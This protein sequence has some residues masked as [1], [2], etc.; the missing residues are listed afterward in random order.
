M[1]RDNTAPNMKDYQTCLSFESLKRSNYLY[2][3]ME[4]YKN[5]YS[6]GTGIKPVD[7]TCFLV[8]I[9]K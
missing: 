3:M 5:E 4:L 1:L 8:L 2:Y 6:H 7:E 9:I